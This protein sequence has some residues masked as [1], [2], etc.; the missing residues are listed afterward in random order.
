MCLVRNQYRI[1]LYFLFI[2]LSFF[3]L[4]LVSIPEPFP[5]PPTETIIPQPIPEVS[6]SPDGKANSNYPILMPPATK[7]LAPSLSL[8]YNSSAGTS[9]LG[10][11]WDLEGI[12]VIARDASYGIHYN[13]NDRFVS[14]I[15]GQLV[16][17]TGNTYYTKYE[18]FL[19]YQKMGNSSNDYWLVTDRNGTKYYFGDT[20]D[21]RL[22]TNTGF[23]KI[24]SLSKVEDVYGN[25][26][27]IAYSTTAPSS[28][29][30]GYLYPSNIT[31]NF[32]RTSGLPLT[33]IS[34]TYENNPI[35]LE[36]YANAS[37]TGT[38]LRSRL[39]TIVI[40]HNGTIFDSYSFSYNTDSANNAFRL[41]QIN[42][43]KFQPLTFTYSDSKILTAANYR[44]INLA[45]DQLDLNYRYFMSEG[46]E[47]CTMTELACACTAN[48]VVCNVGLLIA[49]RYCLEGIV[50]FGLNCT[51]GLDTAQ[52]LFVDIDGDSRADFVAVN[53]NQDSHHLKIYFTNGT[54][55]TNQ[56]FVAL[57]SFPQISPS[58]VLSKD[59]MVLPADA[60]GD[61]K[62]D[63]FILEREEAPLKIIYSNGRSEPT[64][65]TLGNVIVRNLGRASDLDFSVTHFAADL[66]GDGKSDFTYKLL[67]PI[68]G[69]TTVAYLSSQ[70]YVAH[71]L[72]IDDFGTEFQ[73]FIDMDGNGIPDF[74][75]INNSTRRILITFFNRDLSTLRTT[76][77]D[78][79]STI[80]TNGNRFLADV[81]GDGYPDYINYSESKVLQ[82][83]L[84]NG[85][86]FNSHS[87]MPVSHAHFVTSAYIKLENTTSGY[88]ELDADN[89]GQMDQLSRTPDMKFLLKLKRADTFL[90]I[91]LSVDGA[92]LY[93]LDLD[94]TKEEI[95]VTADSLNVYFP[96]S[97]NTNVQTFDPKILQPKSLITEG[98]D[99]E[100]KFQN[101]KL[102]KTFADV[103]GDGK[104]DFVR[105]DG[106]RIYISYARIKN[107]KL[108]YS[109]GGD[110]SIPATAF[111][112]ATDL[113]K[114][115]RADFMGIY[116]ELEVYNPSRPFELGVLRP[117]G[118]L[119]LLSKQYNF[120]THGRNGTLVAKIGS[121]VYTPENVLTKIDGTYQNYAISYTKDFSDVSKVEVN[122]KV[123]SIPSDFRVTTVTKN[124]AVGLTDKDEYSF[125]GGY[126]VYLGDFEKRK[127]LGFDEMAVKYYRNNMLLE[128]EQ[129]SFKRGYATSLDLDLAGQVASTTKYSNGIKISK[130][131]PTYEVITSKFGN[132]IIRS[133]GSAEEIYDKGILHITQNTSVHYDLYGNI[134]SQ[135]M[136]AGS[137]VVETNIAYSTQ[138]ET[139]W[140]FGRPTSISKTINL[141]EVE[142]KAFEYETSFPYRITKF[143]TLVDTGIWSETELPIS[144]YDSY[145]NPTKIQSNGKETNLVYD[146]LLHK[147]ATTVTNSLGQSILSNFDYKTGN[148]LNTTEPNGG[149]VS[150]LYDQYGRNIQTNHPAETDWSE[151]M[152]YSGTG[153]PN[154]SYV[155]KKVKDSSNQADLWTK[156]TNT[157]YT[158]GSFWFSRKILESRIDE[159]NTKRAMQVEEYDEKGRLV[160]KSNSFIADASGNPIAPKYFTNYIYDSTYENLKRVNYPDGSYTLLETNGLVSEQKTFA[161]DNTMISYN[162]EEKN[163]L[164]QV[165]FRTIGTNLAEAKKLSYKYDTAGRMIEAL[166][167]LGKK[168]VMSYRLDGKKK[169]QTDHNTGATTY[170]Y[171]ARGNL[172]RQVDADNRT[173]NFTYD[174]LG[175]IIQISPNAETPTILTYDA[176][177]SNSIGRLASVSDSSG[178]SSFQYDI[179]GNIVESKKQIG[180]FQFVVRQE[181]DSLNRPKRLTYPNGYVANYEYDLAGNLNRISM[182]NKDMTSVNN[183]VV[184]YA[185]SNTGHTIE[186][187]TGNQVVT[188]IGYDPIKLRVASVQTKLAGGQKAQDWNYEYDVMGN[189]KKITDIDYYNKTHTTEYLYD[190]QNRL[191]EATWK[192]GNSL[193]EKEEYKFDVATGNLGAKLE[194]IEDS[195]TGNFKTK[196]TMNYTYGNPSKQK[197]AVTSVAILNEAG[198]N[199]HTIQYQ[200]DNVGNMIQRDNDVFL[201]NQRNKLEKIKK[202]NN[203]D[204]TVQYIY[205]YTGSRVKKVI[206]STNSSVYYLG[207]LYE[208]ARTDGQPDRHTLYV[209]GIQGELVSQL[210]LT[211]VDLIAST[212]IYEENNKYAFSGP[213]LK[214]IQFRSKAVK[215]IV[216]QSYRNRYFF[217]SV[218]GLLFV[219]LCTLYLLASRHIRQAQCELRSM[220]VI[221]RSMN[222]INRLPSGVE[223]TMTD[224]RPDIEHFGNAQYKLHQ[225]ADY[226]YNFGMRLVSILLFL[227]IMG[228]FTVGCGGR[229]SSGETPFWAL[230]AFGTS[231]SQA[232]SVNRPNGNNPASGGGGTYT[233]GTGGGSAGMPVGTPVEGMYFFHP[234]HLGSITMITNAQGTIVSGD[235][236]NTGAATIRYK[237]YGE[238][239]RTNSAGA[240][241]F[242][243]KYTAQENDQ[244][245]GL[246]FYKA[247]YYDPY[248]GR[249]MQSDSVTNVS[250]LTGQD[251][252]Q[253]VDG[254]PVMYR[255]PSGNSTDYSHMFGQMVKH[256]VGG[257]RWASKAPQEAVRSYNQFVYGKH[258]GKNGLADKYARSINGKVYHKLG[259]YLKAFLKDPAEVIGRSLTEARVPIMIAIAAIIIIKLWPLIL[260]GIMFGL[261]Y[262][263]ALIKGYLIGVA[264][265]V[266][267]AHHGYLIGGYSK[268]NL[269]DGIVWDK[270]EARK[271]MRVGLNIGNSINAYKSVTDLLATGGKFGSEMD[272]TGMT[273]EGVIFQGQANLIDQFYGGKGTEYIITRFTSGPPSES[274][275]RYFYYN[276]NP[277]DL[278]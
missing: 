23:A 147:F 123:F 266:I 121:A 72:D 66:D 89:D 106:S 87:D 234:D 79:E 9:M 178:T 120:T 27:K 146:P 40:N 149:I 166:D 93:D 107:Q 129:T 61:A 64:I 163:L 194:Y 96:T 188:E 227:P 70:N 11:G 198:F 206:D 214:L 71:Y 233:G 73:Q 219:I 196:R 140:I 203:P 2:V 114:D 28:Y 173:V 231:P 119:D 205:D 51:Q 225:N 252:Y 94:G 186:R 258:H 167:H 62:T 35:T 30:D 90:E 76:Y 84:F 19:R 180:D 139:N 143:R 32:D 152:F 47:W 181:Y 158:V 22:A 3:F 202:Q 177:G 268:S 54:S 58:F 97:G 172:L 251:L 228:T 103:D 235:V 110:L 270:Y 12:P 254:N 98:A 191:V 112:F 204:D 275:L 199:T 8:V 223:V 82:V 60:N 137:H 29:A 171:D 245:T 132:K 77:S 38:L 33:T 210:T 221:N 264:I 236:D 213:I 267:S 211:N 157:N 101:W 118:V 126:R 17:S 91:P 212:P 248:I 42:K 224:I 208:V 247:R 229:V 239:N 153:N 83:S 154:E 127:P 128:T 81:N 200:Y 7:D 271:G 45:G 14:S 53:G 155:L 135:S 15:G 242:R 189:I 272:E 67:T 85:E 113:N 80:G 75:R 260:L 232:E 44:D 69:K 156:E 190:S 256:A 226:Q 21:S 269:K 104:A 193:A 109:E 16:L 150:K 37:I 63:F 250:S 125:S 68:N 36:E 237:P 49:Q 141:E 238:V 25:Y 265:N 74:I 46:R 138:D 131:T 48:P 164:G 86:K 95:T 230:A 134:T 276:K 148:P 257:L 10:V 192:H 116:S 6:V 273:K 142:S 165:E 122:S 39:R 261:P 240:D 56:D 185:K 161:A 108:F 209:K 1:R 244:E 117:S 145:G 169:M 124:L 159:D 144:G 262:V 187:I 216:N 99:W 41:Y 136:Q 160:L 43:Q 241:I 105:F 100:K 55:S 170:T 255:D 179:R 133:N 176:G 217:Q 111:T 34:F 274:Y 184:N 59:G 174:D 222:I 253:Y 52:N 197:N 220:T 31:F 201:Y 218:A 115:G 195:T 259:A 4:N 243:Y 26:Y 168:T 151:K 65:H 102:N 249:F 130:S 18:S 175:R 78:I 215:F 13:S 278:L 246:Y 182:D 57:N 162:K 207:G 88:V 5:E 50:E 24:W 183:D 263:A 277:F 92:T 20:S